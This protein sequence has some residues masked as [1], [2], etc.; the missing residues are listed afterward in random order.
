[1][2]T[3]KYTVKAGD[4]LSAIARTYNTTVA[5]LVK[6]ND[7]TDPD[8]I[9]IG[10][11]LI[12]SGSTSATAKK[13]NTSSKA[14][15]KAFGIQSGTDRTLYVTWKWDKTNTDNYKI[16]WEYATGDG[17]W[18]RANDTE[19]NIKQATYG[20]PENATSVRFRVR[21]IS[22]KKKV[23]GKESGYH[24]SADWSA[25]KTY[26]FK[27]SPPSTPSVPSVSI[28]KYTLTA[29]LDNID[30]DINA[31]HIQFQIVK[32]DKSVFKTG[33]AAIKTSHASYACKVT[34]GS[35]YKVRCRAVRGNK[36]SE[37][38]N[39][40]NNVA[41]IPSAI[42]KIKTCKAKSETSVY[43]AWSAVKTATSYDIEYATKKE[44]FDGSDQ[45]TVTSG[46]T[47]THYEKTGLDSGE[48]YFFRVRAVNDKGSSAW[49]SIKSTKLGKA[50]SPPT[51]WSS[52]TTAVVGDPL[53]LY[54]VHNS[55]DGSSQTHAQIELTVNGT[56]QIIPL[57]FEETDDDER[58][59]SSYPIDTSDY[60][61][62][63]K[64]QWRVRTRGI[65]S[66][67]SDWSEQR[68]I[69]IYAP[70]TLEILINNMK[71][72]SIDVIE[73]FPFYV[74]LK[75]GPDTQNPIG[76]QLTVTSSQAYKTTD[77]IGNVKMVKKDEAV[78]SEYF[79][80]NHRN[81][82]WE[83]SASN[84]NLESD[85]TYT[86]TCTVSMDSGLTAENSIDIPVS[87]VDKEYE[88]DA[89]IVIDTDTLTASIRPY[90]EQS[91]DKYV[92]TE[93]IIG[94]L[95]G[96]ILEDAVTTTGEDVY[97][98][99]SDDGEETYYT[100]INDIYYEI[101]YTSEIV[102]VENVMLSVY[103]REFDGSFTELA[104]GLANAKDTYIPDPHPAL[105]Y[106][107]YRIVAIDNDTGAVSYYDP[108]GVPVGEKA[109]IIQWDEDWTSFETDTEDELVQ[110]PWEGSLLKLPYNIDVSDNNKPDVALV[111]YIGREH[112][113]S[114]YGTQLGSTATW[115]T[116][117]EKD[118]EETLYALRRLSRWMGDVYVREPSGSGYWANITVSFSQKHRDLTIPVTFNITR[119]AGGV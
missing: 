1:M 49:S 102:S 45:T 10:Q 31:T 40:S 83:L 67:Y 41:T 104:T 20:A 79:N 63:V 119:V 46:I 21:P 95:S 37:W 84:I 107:R 13:K 106:A 15:I 100:I 88:P 3:T 55:E 111:E 18:F 26:N 54:W 35:E 115:N 28:E 110:P 34:A 90:C 4:T 82:D 53:N 77:D 32:D 38:T 80:A 78:Y 25:Y 73:S 105:D 118:D 57:E 71:F 117:I 14:I 76:Y 59:T 116:V 75:A 9:V 30:S 112:P 103:R 11:V 68:T 98:Y 66:T 56:K 19:V 39:Y 48:E 43:L 101:E 52:T 50:P 109:I 51:T 89:E 114:Y 17:I 108:P 70:P 2:A 72:E 113:V 60:E 27:N 93:Y 36:Y 96:D 69:D 64:I 58:I 86:F 42:S 47:T 62:G 99:I 87:W 12:V 8:Y 92:V 16:Q 65:I 61:E 81:I 44:Y 94:A 5:K 22:K 91:I 6:L 24:W 74:T 23:N 85:V 7:I 29:E 33:K 97:L